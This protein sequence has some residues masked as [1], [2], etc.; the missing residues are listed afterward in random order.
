VGEGDAQA[1][2][3]HDA[4][5]DALGLDDVVLLGHAAEVFGDPAGEAVGGLG[6]QVE[7]E[8]AVDFLEGDVGVDEP[9]IGA[10]GLEDGA[11]LG[12]LVVDV[13]GDLLED[14][15]AGDDAGDAAIF[16][17]DDGDADLVLLEAGEQAV[18]GHAFGDEDGGEGGGGEE[19][20]GSSRN[21]R[22]SRKPAMSSNWSR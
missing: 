21:L 22:T 10:G 14:V 7:A 5:A 4:D 17:D 19:W 1:D 18:E 13:A 9:G 2:G 20:A 11:G 12:E 6:L 16:V 8:L 3:L 15:A